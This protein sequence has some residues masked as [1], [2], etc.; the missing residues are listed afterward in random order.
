MSQSSRQMLVQH[1]AQALDAFLTP[2]ATRHL[3]SLDT[4]EF[5]QRFMAKV[6][7][8]VLL[9]DPRLVAQGVATVVD[10]LNLGVVQFD[11]VSSVVGLRL[12]APPLP[13][14]PDAA[15]LEALLAEARAKGDAD[16]VSV[17]SA[18]SWS[19]RHLSRS[20][21]KSPHRRLAC[22]PA[23]LSLDVLARHGG[24]GW[25]HICSALKR[26][27]SDAERGLAAAAM[28]TCQVD[29]E[30]RM[31]TTLREAPV[32]LVSEALRLAWQGTPRPVRVAVVEAVRVVRVVRAAASSPAKSP[33]R[34][35]AKSPARSPAGLS[36]LEALLYSLS[37][38]QLPL[39][40]TTLT[41][42]MDAASRMARVSHLDGLVGDAWALESERARALALSFFFDAGVLNDRS[43]L[44]AGGP[45]DFKTI[46]LGYAAVEDTGARLVVANH[47]VF[48]EPLPSPFELMTPTPPSPA[49]ASL[50]EPPPPPAQPAAPP[51]VEPRD[52]QV[53]AAEEPSVQDL[54]NHEHILRLFRALE[55]V[56]LLARQP[57][58][59]NGLEV[60]L[61]EQQQEEAQDDEAVQHARTLQ[62]RIETIYDLFAL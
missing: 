51:R 18:L 48:D 4:R 62:S 31:R 50:Q 28:L 23:A 53:L 60:G 5:C 16:M 37:A 17:L 8:G 19:G 14:S 46:L 44:E 59:E 52:E 61:Q 42:E 30:T 40:L 45:E 24:A 11:T 20:P 7:G 54:A 27:R 2:D 35:P 57:V 43:L 26:L 38:A 41:V 32:E 13:P 56:S 36:Q 39:A 21:A 12:N 9:H 6:G 10:P 15:G 49:P 55:E 58:P 47:A 25:A 22:G 33:A 34:S 3:P 29:A 1:G